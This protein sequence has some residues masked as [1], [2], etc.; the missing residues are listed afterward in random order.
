MKRTLSIFIS[1][2]MMFSCFAICLSAN[3]VDYSTPACRC[4]EH[5]DGPEG[6]HCCIYCPNLDMDYVTDCKIDL[7]GNLDMKRVGYCIEDGKL[8][9]CEECT[10]VYPC[11][12]GHDCCHPCL[13]HHLFQVGGCTCCVECPQLNE[14][15]LKITNCV[16]DE[17]GNLDKSKLGMCYDIVDGEKVY[18][19]C[20]K[21]TGVFPCDCGHDC[22]HP[23]FNHVEEKDACGCCVV[24]PYLNPEYLKTLTRCVQDEYGKLD[25]EKF[26]TCIDENGNRVQCDEC[27]GIWP[28]TCGHPCC[29]VNENIED[30]NGHNND[31]ILSEDQQENFTSAFQNFL[32]SVKEFF[33]NFFDVIFRLLGI[34]N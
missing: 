5:T 17:N 29:S 14:K 7:Y 12:C 19:E 31:P 13:D 18:V 1:L 10:G 22:C 28:C 20:D 16:K 32:K 11:N 24:C 23:C 15:N 4:V 27:T 21:C 8:V 2:V 6:C 30:D 9:R 25:A 33:D 26:G 34:R 3:A